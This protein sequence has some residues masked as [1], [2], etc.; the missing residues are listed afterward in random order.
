M[1]EKLKYYL[2]AFLSGLFAANPSNVAGA[3]GV[4]AVLANL[5]GAW[6]GWMGPEGV[7]GSKILKGMLRIMI[8]FVSFNALYAALKDTLFAHL[9]SAIY[10]VIAL[11]EFLL[12]MDKAACVGI[13][14]RGLLAKL[15]K[16]VRL[17]QK[18]S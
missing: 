18:D 11:Y 9:L 8:Y 10:T 15:Q 16:N 17:Q 5:L 2:F 4:L 7:R 1:S 13:V 6:C 12:L 14:P 3:V